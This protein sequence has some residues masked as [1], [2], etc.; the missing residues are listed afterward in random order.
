MKY[1]ALLTTT[2]LKEFCATFYELESARFAEMKVNPDNGHTMFKVTLI[3]DKHADFLL[4]HAFT[5]GMRNHW[6]W[7]EKFQKTQ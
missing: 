2:E 4:D 3:P 5:E 1:T 6:E 7:N